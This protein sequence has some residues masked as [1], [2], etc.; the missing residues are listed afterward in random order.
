MNEG[1]L[2]HCMFEFVYLARSDSVWEGRNIYAVREK[3][4]EILAELYPIKVD[5]V[6]PAPDS[7]RSAATGYSRKSGI[8]I[9]DALVKNSYVHRTFIMPGEMQRKNSVKLKLNAIKSMVEG[10]SI[11][12]VDDSLVRGNTMGKIVSLLKEAGAKEVHVMISCPK[13]IAPCFMGIDFPTYRELAAAV[14]SV[15][16]ISEM[17][18]ADS[19]NYMTIEGLV[20][21][22][23]LPKNDLCLACLTDEYPTRER[24]KQ[25]EA[26]KQKLLQEKLPVFQ[27]QVVDKGIL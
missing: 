4:G 6:V 25:A 18:G 16:E 27:E 14:H 21:A 11:V 15:E 19:L 26:E 7:G 13:I 23:G 12:L 9:G 8:P 22:I 3:L 2:A 17:I 5:L 24:P 20:K 1:R 10:K